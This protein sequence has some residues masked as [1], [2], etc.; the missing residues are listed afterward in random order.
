MARSPISPPPNKARLFL[1]STRKK[2]PAQMHQAG[3]VFEKDES[4]GC[5]LL[6]NIHGWQGFAF[7]E[8]EEST[9]TG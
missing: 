2:H 5:A 9:A 3:W 7:E 1:S 6:Q 8:F 4:A